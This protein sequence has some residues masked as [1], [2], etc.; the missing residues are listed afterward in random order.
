M[1]L[2]ISLLAAVAMQ[3]APPDWRVLNTTPER[4]MSWDASGVTRDGETATVRIRFIH[5]PARQGA[6]AYAI[7]RVEIRCAA[8]L[9]RVVDTVNYSADGIAGQRDV[10]QMP[11]DAIPPDSFINTVRTQVCTPP[12][13]AR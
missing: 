3:P 9:V 12:T 11:F 2:S 13:V 1:I 6:N 8:G 4:E 5:I 7:S 10:S